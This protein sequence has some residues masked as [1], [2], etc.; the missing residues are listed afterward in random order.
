MIIRSHP[1]TKNIVLLAL[2]PTMFFINGWSGVFFLCFCGFRFVF[3]VPDSCY[4]VIKSSYIVK[5]HVFVDLIG[6]IFLSEL[7]KKVPLYKYCDV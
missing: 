7:I 2:Q 3:E 6:A 5:S 4:S 1:N